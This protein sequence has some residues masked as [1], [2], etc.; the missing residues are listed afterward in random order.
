M[1]KINKMA[2]N[3]ILAINVYDFISVKTVKNIIIIV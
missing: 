2:D 1:L 3:Q